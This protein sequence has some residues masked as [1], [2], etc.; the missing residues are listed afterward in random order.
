MEAN[1]E[2]VKSVAVREEAPK[3]EAAAETSEALKERY[4][5]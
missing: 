1:P 5:D 2:A 3:E 4:G